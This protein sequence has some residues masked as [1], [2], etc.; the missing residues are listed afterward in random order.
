M[1]QI[2]V[3]SRHFWRVGRLIIGASLVGYSTTQIAT[4]LTIAQARKPVVVATTNVLCDVTKTIAQDTIELK[5]LVEAG[6]D[7]HVHEPTPADARAIE[8]ANLILY[9]GYDFEPD[10]IKMIEATSNTA[11]KIAVSEVAVP[12]PIM[13]EHHDHDHEEERGAESH[14]HSAEE[15]EHEAA[16]A[17]HG[18]EEALA[19]DPHVFHSAENG[20]A[21]AKVVGQELTKILP[22]Q[23]AL[24]QTNTERLAGELTQMHSWIKQ[25]IAT[26]PE[27]QRQL[28]TTHDAFAYYSAAYNIPV[29]GALQG[30]STE[31]RPTAGRVAELVEAIRAARV[32]RIF[33]E[34]SINPRLIS[35]VSRE[36]RVPL[37]D[38]ELYADGIGEA[39]SNGN[40]YPKMLMANTR[41]IVEGL[42]GKYTAFSPAAPALGGRTPA[43]SIPT[44]TPR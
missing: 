42:G 21:I 32:P 44:G 1:L 19:P 33:A 8:T 15:H 5:C 23:A 2:S 16:G 7:P 4:A 31:E 40:T 9:A 10:I 27:N 26:I 20:A 37:S 14:A 36:A 17:E 30:V 24:Y 11:P 34:T 41:A 12:Q 22:S 38:N 29:V 28:V 13:G 25:Q 35:A 43:L 3:K 39:D 6:S 18:E